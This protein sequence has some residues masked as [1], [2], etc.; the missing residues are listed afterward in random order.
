MQEIPF[1][2]D[3][4][5][6][7]SL[8]DAWR[9]VALNWKVY[10][11]R[12]VPFLLFAA[13]STAF[14][15]ALALLYM[16]QQLCPAWLF[17]Q[18]RGEAE[19]AKQIALP[20][21][22]NAIYLSLALALWLFS[23]LIFLTKSTTLIAEYKAVNQFLATTSPSITHKEWHI[24]LKWL[25]TSALTLFGSGLLIGL[26]VAAALKWT[27]WLLIPIPFIALFG[28]SF[29]LLFSLKHTLFEQSLKSSS[30]YALKH[31]LGTPFIAWLLS[32]IP[33]GLILAIC[34]CPLLLYIG[35]QWAAV[36][37]SLTGDAVVP[38]LLVN[39]LYFLINSLCLSIAILAASYLLWTVTLK[40]NKQN[41]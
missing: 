35:S 22:A 34:S 12:I 26:F 14:F 25:Y 41:R 18:S 29:G 36:Q 40:T 15:L 7:S 38:P 1:N 30:L 31:A 8:A 37:S 20:T 10:L 4:G 21:A 9:I 39:L 23:Q 6:K 33:V 24:C 5:I 17:L 13:T 27:L 16:R 11:K 3:R 2:K 19:I 32:F 28:S